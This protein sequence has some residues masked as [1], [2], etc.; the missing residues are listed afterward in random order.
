[1]VSSGKIEGPESE[2][3]SRQ[4]VVLAIP[5]FLT[6]VA[7]PVFLLADSAIVGHLGTDQLAGLGAAGSILSAASSLFIFLAYAT[8]A[9]VARLVG[10]DR[11][12]AA[13]QGGVQSIWLALVLGTVVSAIGAFT[14]RSLLDAISTPSS[15]LPYANTYLTIS[16]VGIAPILISMAGIGLLRGLGEVRTTLWIQ[17]ISYLLNIA[18]NWEFVYPLHLGIAGSALGTVTAQFVSSAAYVWL[19]GAKAKAAGASLRPRFFDILSDLAGGVPLLVR[20]LTLRAAILQST[21]VAAGIG[22]V[23]LA[24]HQVAAN[25]WSFSA[26]ALDAI[27]LAG[28]VIIGMSLGKGDIDGAM[29][30]SKTMIRWGALAG[31]LSAGGIVL[32]SPFAPILFSSDPRVRQLLSEVLVVV[33][34][35]QPIGGVVYVLD[36]ILIGAGD[37]VYLSFAGLFSLV[38]FVPLALYVHFHHNTLIALW[39]A[40]GIF[41]TARMTTLVMRERSG[42]WARTGASITPS[43]GSWPDA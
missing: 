33:A 12:K 28:Q 31:L 23:A 15:A 27:A 26:F 24:S 36:G 10:A 9:R 22:S 11:V 6:I 2:A 25:I 38:C 16:L 34:L 37:G 8:T 13:I 32:L 43:Q 21:W 35:L 29:S 4:L 19:I 3:I 1:M 42:R 41:M 30:A 17:V 14:V 18:L 39:L 7:E 40:Y 5:I 20:T